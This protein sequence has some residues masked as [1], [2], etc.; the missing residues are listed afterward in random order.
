MKTVLLLRHAK[1]E[2]GN[3]GLADFD[4]PLA[5]RG[6]KDAPRIGQVLA[7]YDFIPDKILASPARRAKQTAELVAEA[8]SYKKAA[9]AWQESFYGGYSDDLIAAL[10]G[11]PN[12][13][14]RAML[15]GH[16]PAMEE[17]A[18]ALLI[19]DTDEKLTISIPTA[20]LLCLDLDI[21]TWTDLEPGD[22]ILR[23]YLIPKLIKAI[24]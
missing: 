12:S 14:N 19:G 15:V 1:S 4:R 3:P 18:A 11:L 16:N 23:W 7:N 13:V 2:W 24:A 22:A 5:E 6:L 20:G 10:Q 9:I 17:A 21:M 8:C